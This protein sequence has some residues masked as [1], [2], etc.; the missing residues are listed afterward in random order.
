MYKESRKF[1]KTW[2]L[3]L[4]TIICHREIFNIGKCTFYIEHQIPINP[5][6]HALER[7]M[8]VLVHNNEKFHKHC[9]L[10][11]RMS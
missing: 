11:G 1:I 4:L 9:K 8:L 3:H 10:G 7:F 6:S 2:L 5:S